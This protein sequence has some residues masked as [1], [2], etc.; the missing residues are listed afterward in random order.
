MTQT[1]LH[2]SCII[3]ENK[4]VK[5]PNVCESGLLNSNCNEIK[6]GNSLNT[7]NLNATLRISMPHFEPQLDR[8]ISNKQAQVLC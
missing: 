8:I 3:Q 1:K 4:T 7:D 5:I 6:K 2:N